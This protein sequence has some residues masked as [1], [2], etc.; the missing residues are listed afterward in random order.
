MEKHTKDG[1]L[2]TAEDL[3]NKHLEKELKGRDYDEPTLKAV[4]DSR[5]YKKNPYIQAAMIEFAKL[6]VK[7][8][9]ETANNNSKILRQPTGEGES[10]EIYLGKEFEGDLGYE[11]YIP[12]SYTIDKDSILNA[13]P[14]ENIK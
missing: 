6:H 11:D 14:E 1:N 3:F 5:S 4:R 13:Y 9:L 8:A 10:S 12:V 7:A 2:P